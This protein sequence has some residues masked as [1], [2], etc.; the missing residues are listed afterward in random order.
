MTDGQTVLHELQEESEMQ[1]ATETEPASKR[2][3]RRGSSGVEKSRVWGNGSFEAATAHMMTDQQWVS[4]CNRSDHLLGVAQNS[5]PHSAWG[6]T[7]V[8][9][10]FDLRA[11]KPPRKYSPRRASV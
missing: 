7:Y 10:P 3:P 8:K 9:Q 5:R 6:H 4:Y 11:P 1:N 2:A